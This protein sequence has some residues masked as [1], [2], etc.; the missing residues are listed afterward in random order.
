M[1]LF[2]PHYSLSPKLK[3]YKV[4]E[5]IFSCLRSKLAYENGNKIKDVFKTNGDRDI[6]SYD[7]IN[8]KDVIRNKVE[9][10]IAEVIKDMNQ[11]PI[12]YDGL[13]SPP[14]RDAQ[15][16]M[17]WKKNTVYL[18]FRGLHDMLDIVD[19]F[20][21]KPRKFKND[22]AIH[23]GFYAQFMSLKNNI[24]SDM[25]NIIDSYPIERIVLTG[26]SM[27]GA[28]ACIAAPYFS[29]RYENMHITCHT[30]GMPM[31]GN[32]EFVK[33]FVNGVDE[34]VRLELEED[35]VPKLPVNP[36]FC[37][38]PNGVRLKKSGS[39]ENFYKDEV[40]SCNAV[41]E[42]M[43]WDNDAVHDNHTCET[44]IERL[45]SLKQIRKPQIITHKEQ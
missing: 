24:T 37:H 36:E 42:K 22:V 2:T 39:V 29:E 38:I 12:F 14:K 23:S 10:T 25:D 19:A 30:F 43:I 17:L 41:I 35:I 26:H 20:N 44:H 5:M 32:S 45:L 40:I 1:A 34:C 16:F 8:C 31:L 27:G 6:L 4:Q 11:T 13:T 33:W 21:T 7:L 3:P 9:N 15:G 18:S 28:I